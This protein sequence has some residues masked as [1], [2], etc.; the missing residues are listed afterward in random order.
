MDL[1]TQIRNVYLELTEA[2]FYSKEG[3]IL[4]KDDSD[5]EGAYIAKWEYL[6]PIP[7]GMKLGK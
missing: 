3:T 2:D 1:F 4:L 7:K 6:K 5:G